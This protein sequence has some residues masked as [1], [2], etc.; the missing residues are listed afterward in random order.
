MSVC[1]LHVACAQLSRY[2]A[3]WM[4]FV[5]GNNSLVQSLENLFCFSVAGSFDLIARYY[6][7]V[8]SHLMDRHE[9]LGVLE[10]HNRM[11]HHYWSVEDVIRIANELIY[12]LKCSKDVDGAV[13]AWNQLITP[14]IDLETGE[15]LRKPWLYHF[16]LN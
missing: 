9:I 6:A 11:F 8:F 16:F 3:S 4:K 13:N 1:D 10:Y 15:V 2:R 14:S 7:L 12:C 5:D